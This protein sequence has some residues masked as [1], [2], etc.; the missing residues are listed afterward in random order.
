MSKLDHEALAAMGINATTRISDN[1]KEATARAHDN[2]PAEEQRQLLGVATAFGTTIGS[3]LHALVEDKSAIAAAAARDG[4]DPDAFS[5]GVHALASGIAGGILS[6]SVEL[7]RVGFSK[8][9]ISV[10]MAGLSNALAGNNRKPLPEE[11]VPDN[12]I[13][14]PRTKTV[15]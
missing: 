4:H 9:A 2:L 10:F 15:H 7:E 3:A 13:P 5:E 1:Y 8:A 11:G 12:V 6:M 14:L